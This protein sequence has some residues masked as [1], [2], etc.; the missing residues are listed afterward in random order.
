MG[1]IQVLFAY[2]NGLL[3]FAVNNTSTNNKDNVSHNVAPFGQEQLTL[4]FGTI[5]YYTESP[6]KVVIGKV[7]LSCGV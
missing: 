2:G 4:L 1:L 6:W 7:C 3:T 5:C